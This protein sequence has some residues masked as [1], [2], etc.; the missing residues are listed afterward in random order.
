MQ[1]IRKDFKDLGRDQVCCIETRQDY[2]K[3][4]SDYETE[5][6]KLKAD[7][8][9]AVKRTK[10]YVDREQLLGLEVTDYYELDGMID[11]FN[12]YYLLWPL[13]CCDS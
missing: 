9:E 1:K 13:G 7:L 10:S 8:D 6:Y 3:G 4:L 2:K 12:P 11:D 5:V